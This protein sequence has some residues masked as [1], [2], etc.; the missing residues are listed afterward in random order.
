MP[1]G[2]LSGTL[3]AAQV[4]EAGLTAAGDITG[5]LNATAIA[6]NSIGVQEPGV[7]ANDEIATRVW[8]PRTSATTT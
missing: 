1:G 7:N 4:S 2:D 3:A 5:A 8:T 6:N